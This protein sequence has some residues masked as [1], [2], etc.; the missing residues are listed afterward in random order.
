MEHSMEDEMETGDIEVMVIM[1]EIIPIASLVAYT[2]CDEGMCL[3]PMNPL[4][5]PAAENM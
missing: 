1:N 3:L 5:N 2:A 4:L